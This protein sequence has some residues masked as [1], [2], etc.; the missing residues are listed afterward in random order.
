MI[1]TLAIVVVTAI[2]GTSFAVVKDVL[3]RGATPHVLIGLRYAIAALIFLPWAWRTRRQFTRDAVVCA[4]FLGVIHVLALATQTVGMQTT[5]ATRSAFLTSTC[6]LVVPVLTS[7]RLRRAVN[8]G[9]IAGILVASLGLLLLLRPDL[10][11]G[12]G[13][14][15]FTLSCALLYAVYLVCLE[16]SLK[17]HSY[18]PILYVQ[19]FVVSLLA[20]AAA[21]VLETPAMPWTRPALID[22]VFLALLPTAAA[23][24]LQNRYSGRVSADRAALIYTAEPVFAA[25][26]ARLV[27]GETLP[28]LGY[29]GATLVLAGILL[30]VRPTHAKAEA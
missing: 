16:E 28:A 1:P 20:F 18:E 27:L 13:G 17:R 26:F 12:T 6:C 30:G 21:P 19:L 15:L 3:D 22:V 10:S 25:G 11:Q 9:V 23:L 29:A 14:D 4:S 2:W 24:F 5:T 7:L 8:R